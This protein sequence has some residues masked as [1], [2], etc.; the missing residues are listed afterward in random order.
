[1]SRSAGEA[2]VHGRG[3]RGADG[4]RR[5]P[6]GRR[7]GR[8]DPGRL[9]GPRRRSSRGR[10]TS[11][12]SSR[13]SSRCSAS[14]AEINGGYAS[15]VAGSGAGS[16]ERLRRF[17]A[18]TDATLSRL[19][20]E[21]LLATLLDRVRD[22]MDVDTAVFLLL[23]PHAQQLVATAAWGLEEE[24]RQGFRVSVG[25]GFAGRVARDRAPVILDEVTAAE[26]ASPIR[27]PRASA[28]CSACRSSAAARWSACCT[29]AACG[30]ARS[31][32][33]TSACSSWSP[34]G[35]AW[36]AR[37]ARSVDRTA[38]L[39]LQRSLLPTAAAR[40][41]RR[42]AG[43]PLPA[44]ATTPASAATGTTCSPC[45]PAGSAWSSATCPATACARPS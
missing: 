37:P 12:R 24:V 34:T 15:P 44:R 32:P 4:R 35:P 19:D 38:A 13:T 5:V 22:L 36:P 40:R 39:A 31:R 42:R 21:D 23:D 27:G 16:D 17:E 2:H 11:S 45:R 30:R 9:Q 41:V 3:P 1:M 43:R 33:T 29:S 28:R 18:V 8:R 6:Q 10:P 25:H 14:R 20:A 26:V 7:G